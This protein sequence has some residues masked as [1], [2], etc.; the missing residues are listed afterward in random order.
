MKNFENILYALYM[1]TS[2][3]TSKCHFNENHS[4][5]F[6][7]EA[8]NRFL[9]RI[10]TSDQLTEQQITTV[11][12]WYNQTPYTWWIDKSN[13]DA[14]NILKQLGYKELATFPFMMLAIKNVPTIKIAPQITICDE[15]KINEI[16]WA[17]VVGNV[18]KNEVKDVLQFYRYLKNTFGDCVK[19]YMLYINNIPASTAFITFN[20]Q[21]VYLHYV[22]TTEQLRSQGLATLLC[23]Y[24]LNNTK[25]SKQMY[26][27]S[28]AQGYPLY[29]KMGFEDVAQFVV[30]QK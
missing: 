18:Y 21:N 24:I 8:D 10:Y 5:G 22:A 29:K 15:Q 4:Y 17:T 27:F 25:T 20:E 6:K 14:I 1:P 7:S 16:E 23:N 12:T 9:N 28:S 2:M 3:T 26:L 13:S 11:E 19:R 30:F